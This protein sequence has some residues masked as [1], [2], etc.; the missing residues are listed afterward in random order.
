MF[1]LGSRLVDRPTPFVRFT[2]GDPANPGASVGPRRS[3]SNP[4]AA[5]R[6]KVVILVDEM[7][8]EPGRVHDHGLP[9]RAEARRGQHDRGSGRQRLADPA[10]RRTAHR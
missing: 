9:L 1:E 7:S 6:G 5:L 2:R 4:P 10:A 3:R 8:A